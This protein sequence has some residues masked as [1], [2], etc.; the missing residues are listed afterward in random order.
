VR[1]PEP[2]PGRVVRAWRFV[3]VAWVAA[4]IYAGYKSIQLWSRIVGDARKEERYRRQDGRAARALYRSAVRLQG[5][6]IKACQFIATRADVLPDAW[7]NTLSGLHDH[8][9]P[10]RFAAIRERVE[11]ELG[12]SLDDVFAEFDPR[13]LASASL[14][15]VHAARLRDGR[16]CA[17]KVQY[18]GIEG[19]VRA[20]L[21]N[22]AVILRVLA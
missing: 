9:P 8:V 20:D 15:Q 1:A 22:L 16:R 21:R 5:M 14:A 17:V 12:R 6:L 7:V 3:S 4:R 10:R 13:P 19:I 18:P 11:R 2:E